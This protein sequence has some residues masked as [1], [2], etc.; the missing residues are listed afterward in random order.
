LTHSGPRARR[1]L[2][3][4]KHQDKAFIDRIERGFDFLG[5]HFG[6]EAP[7]CV[8]RTCGDGEGGRP[9]AGHLSLAAIRRTAQAR[10]TVREG[11]ARPKGIPSGLLNRAAVGGLL[12]L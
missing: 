8:G 6:P 5:N 10:Q 1:G 9:C 11:G 7:P 12:M 4:V 2:D 3:L